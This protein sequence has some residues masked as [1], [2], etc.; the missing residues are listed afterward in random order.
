MHVTPLTAV[1]GAL[2]EVMAET[3]TYPSVAADLLNQAVALDDVYRDAIVA[4]FQDPEDVTQTLVLQPSHIDQRRAHRIFDEIREYNITLREHVPLL[5]DVL[6]KL[7]DMAHLANNILPVFDREPRLLGY[8]HNVQRNHITY[9]EV[10]RIDLRYAMQHYF[11]LA[12]EP[13][14]GANVAYTDPRVIDTL[15]PYGFGV[16]VFLKLALQPDWME[17][18]RLAPHIEVGATSRPV[19]TAAVTEDEDGTIRLG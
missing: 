11:G 5:A 4:E 8:V 6:S 15:T 13:V 14:F 16:L 18:G 7:D 3:V 10:A 17:S 12:P 19:A 2:R 1:S 9:I